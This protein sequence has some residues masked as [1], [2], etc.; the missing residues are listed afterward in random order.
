MQVSR[1][2]EQHIAVFGESGSGKTVLLSSFYGA[3]Q[4]PHY[5]QKSLFNVVADDI[6]QGSRLQR[7][8]LG[9]RDAAKVPDT[10]RFAATSYSFSVKLRDDSDNNAAKNRPFDAVRLVWHDYP[11]DWFEQNVSGSE[12]AQRRIDT[13]KS[14]LGSDV[15]FLMVDGQR[16]MD[17]E[18]EEER[19]LKSLFSNFRNALLTLKDDLLDD[20]KPL[21]EFPRIWIIALSKADLFPE[22]NVYKFRDLL[23]GKVCDEI[24]ELRKALAGLIEGSSALSVGEDFVLL[25]SAKFDPGKISVTER[26]GIEL[27]LPIATVLPFERHVRWMHAKE[28]PGKVAENLLRGAGTLAVALVGRNSKVPGRVGRMLKSLDPRLV[29]EAARLA[30]DQLKKM[31][32]DA[33]SKHEQMQAV[34]TG[35]KIELGKGE[36][37]QIL[38][39]SLR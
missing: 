26:I 32:S 3:T 39:R 33:Q 8:Y 4:E 12:E 14:L 10:T 1:K 28:L 6:G 31:N 36:R 29:D 22:M 35:F 5:L 24:D 21:V 13:F 2:L 30:G 17:N 23:I 19:Y 15:A 11:G 20:G 37:D 27:I 38:L 34:L 16:L 7:N 25:S 9:M 18:G